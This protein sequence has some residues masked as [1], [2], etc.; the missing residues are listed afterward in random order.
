MNHCY[1][2]SPNFKLFDFYVLQIFNFHEITFNSIHAHNKVELSFALC[3]LCS[4]HIPV[5]VW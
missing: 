2:F 5:T 1:I 3:P 4:A